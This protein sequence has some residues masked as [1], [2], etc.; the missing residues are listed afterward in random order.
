MGILRDLVEQKAFD[1]VKR[2]IE[3]EE[4]QAL[5]NTEDIRMYNR[6]WLEKM[7]N[8]YDYE[9]SDN[10]T[11]VNRILDKLNERDGHCPCG[12]MTEQFI[13]PCEMMRTHGVCKCGLYK[14]AVD[15]NPRESETTGK[16]KE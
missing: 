9:I 1:I 6:I 2:R 16:I 4:S 5:T 8:H 3:R 13:C 14:N 7:A 10:D 11:A 15:L 12:G